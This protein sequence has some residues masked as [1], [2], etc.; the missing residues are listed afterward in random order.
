[1]DASEPWYTLMIREHILSGFAH[2]TSEFPLDVVV[3]DDGISV[4]P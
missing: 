1:M 3:Y 4:I 2:N